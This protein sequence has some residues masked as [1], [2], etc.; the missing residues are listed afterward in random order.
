MPPA[1]LTMSNRTGSLPAELDVFVGRRTELADIRRLASTSSSLTLVGMGGVGKTRLALRA[2]HGLRRS[3]GD[4]VTYV[5][6][7]DLHDPALLLQ[8]IAEPLGLQE[9]SRTLDLAALVA[10]LTTERR[11]I[12]LDCCE[13]LSAEVADLVDRLLK[14]CAELHVL[15]TSRQPLGVSG[16]VVIRVDPLPTPQPAERPPAIGQL[17]TYD[18]V[19][20]FLERAAVSAPSMAVV[21]DDDT[22]TVARICARLEGIPL[23]LELAAARLRTLTLRQLADRLDKPYDLLTGHTANA[24]RRH[25]T[26]RLCIDS[27]YEQCGASE[28]L[29]WRRSAVFVGGFDLEAVEET[30]GFGAISSHEVLD[31]LSALVDKSMVLRDTTGAGP[32]FRLVETLREYALERLAEAGETEEMRRRHSD[33]FTHCVERFRADLIGP[34]QLALAAGIDLDLPNIRAALEFNIGTSGSKA[35]ALRVVGALNLYWVSRGLLSEGRYWASR[36]LDLPDVG[37]VG[38]AEVLAHFSAVML[39]GLQGDIVAAAGAT[40]ACHRTAR[41]VAGERGE[42]HVAATSGL[43]AMFTGDLIAAV[44]DLD[45][46]AE[47][48]RRIDDSALHIETKIAAGLAAALLGDQ[49]RSEACNRQVLEITTAAGETWLRAYSLWTYGLARW[50]AGSLVEARN[51]LEESLRL[52]QQMSDPL[53]SAWCLEVLAFVAADEEQYERA[54]VLLGAAAALSHEAGTPTATFPDLASAYHAA[55]GRTRRHLGTSG[56]DL[57]FSRGREMDHARAVD[58]ALGVT[59]DARPSAATSTAHVVLTPRQV[60]VARL[61]ARGKTNRAIADELVISERT[62]QGHVENI[63]VRLSFTSRSQIAAWI[64]E[65]SNA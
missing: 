44:V 27:S 58:F 39:A 12:V 53:G 21:G 48:Y 41:R 65:N 46:A 28:R 8:S 36:A 43:L 49:A 1:K 6:L 55:V 45:R 10:F 24:P 52:R 31:L 26:L 59:V 50:R 62:A 54:A 3:F 47:C 13:H 18:G 7:G 60:E 17:G 15:A 57:H 61:V 51:Q 64:V 33:W 20:L 11:L 32:Q 35:D 2:A 9:R 34:R 29:L 5:E 4:A 42:A 22:P 25:Q 30:C 38:D 56:F 37:D 40:T 19:R 63:L 14:G 23:A 16:E